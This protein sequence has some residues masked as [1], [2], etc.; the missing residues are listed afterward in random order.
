MGKDETVPEQIEVDP[1]EQV[2]QVQQDGADVLTT[3][4]QKIAD[5]REALDAAPTSD[6]MKDLRRA[7]SDAEKALADAEAAYATA[8]AQ[9]SLVH[10][11]TTVA[12]EEGV[13]AKR[14]HGWHRQYVPNLPDLSSVPSVEIPREERRIESLRKQVERSAELDREYE[15]LRVRLAEKMEG[16][17]K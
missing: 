1:V 13:S 15:A 2:Q 11:W 17:K 3:N 14:L 12:E 5:W 4:Q 16:W 8:S 10:G 7:I 6:D 9:R